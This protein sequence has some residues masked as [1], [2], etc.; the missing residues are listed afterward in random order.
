MSDHGFPACGIYA[1]WPAGVMLDCYAIAP[2]LDRC[3]TGELERYSPPPP[4]RVFW[5]TFDEIDDVCT[6]CN[7]HLPQFIE[8]WETTCRECAF[9]YCAASGETDDE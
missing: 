7:Q 5:D 9:D 4:W 8:F 3:D 2:G 1:E 6:W